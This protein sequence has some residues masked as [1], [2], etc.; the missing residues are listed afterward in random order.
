MNL[1]LRSPVRHVKG[2]G[3]TYG[4]LLERRRIFSVFD[5]LLHFPL[6]HIDL[7][8]LAEQA[9][10][11]TAQLCRLDVEQTRLNRHFARRLSTLH[12]SGRVGRSPLRLVFFNKPYLL[13]TFQR[14]RQVLVYGQVEKRNGTCQMV[15]PLVLNDAERP[16]VLP[17]YASISTIKSGTIRNL[18]AASLEQLENEPEVLPEVVCRRLRF[19][20]P[21]SCL[22]A[23]HFPQK[24]QPLLVERNKQRFRY[25]ELFFF[26]LELELV[27]RFFKNRQRIHFYRYDRRL[28]QTVDRCLPFPLTDEQVRVFAEIV[29]DLLS[30]FSMQRLLQG[31]VGSGKTILAFLALLI[32]CANGHQ[33]AFL[34][35][36]EILAFQHHQS[37]SRFFQSAKIALLT[38][39]TDR[40]RR[41][42]IEEQLASGAIDIV[43]GTHALLGETPRFKNLGLIVIDEQHRFGVSQRAALFT[44]GRNVDVLVTT[45]T[46]IPRTLQLGLFQDLSISTLEHGPADRRPIT[47]RLIRSRDRMAFYSHL[48]QRLEK[49]EKGYIILPL[50]EKSEFF[51]GLRSIEEEA[52]FFQELFA[53]IP[54]GIIS[55]RSGE[56]EKN[57]LLVR[58][59]SGEIRLLVAT[60]VVEVGIDV[61]DATFMVIENADRYGLAQLH[62]LR[63]R[64]G[65]GRLPSSCF[66][67]PSDTI[68]SGGRLRLQTIIANSDGFAIADMD[69]RMRGGG[70]ITGLEQSGPLDFRVAESQRDHALLEIARQDAVAVLEKSAWQT[71]AIVDFIHLTEKKIGA[72][73]F[74]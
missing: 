71:P 58:F 8:V 20:D 59:R 40:A 15:N 38:G 7:S 44:K 22:K 28:K 42:E 3:E 17:V 57:S 66:L 52:P 32:G 61:A 25:G 50:I 2:I 27:R 41:H 64:V 5:L 63:G 74:S 53:G 54:L 14:E 60:T 34:A 21:V 13:D 18:I 46:P 11:G 51:S 45:A 36:T 35:P 19:A 26:H 29:G 43:F 31:E 70:I 67:L 24:F 37:A 49:G 65:R 23:I 73:S 4:R 6:F 1:Q 62:Q 39:S 68:T 10:P 30:P 12:V 9:V 48:R 47:T 72:L 56:S 69:L 55:G 33:G 16:K